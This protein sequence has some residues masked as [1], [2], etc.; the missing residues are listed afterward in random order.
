[1]TAGGATRLC[2][3]ETCRESD[4]TLGTS[5]ELHLPQWSTDSK[6]RNEIEVSKKLDLRCEG[7]QILIVGKQTQIFDAANLE[8]LGIRHGILYVRRFSGW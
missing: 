2:G 8:I 4:I 3:H 7:G 5:S 6:G 1:M